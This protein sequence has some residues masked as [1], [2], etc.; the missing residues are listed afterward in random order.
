MPGLKG[1][2]LRIPPQGYRRLRAAQ[3]G[4]MGLSAR[5]VKNLT[6]GLVVADGKLRLSLHSVERR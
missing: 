1:W 5:Q 3:R 4:L 2:M 6:A